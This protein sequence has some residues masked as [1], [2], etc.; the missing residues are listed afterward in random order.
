MGA[1]NASGY[2]KPISRFISEMMKVRVIVTIEGKYETIP[3]LLN[4]AI[5]NDLK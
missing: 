3:K 5:F 2:E 1:S 4:G